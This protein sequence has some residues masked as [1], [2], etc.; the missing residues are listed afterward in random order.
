MAFHKSDCQCGSCA[1]YRRNRGVFSLAS[2]IALK[3]GVDHPERRSYFADWSGCCEKPTK[4]ARYV[5]SRSHPETVNRPAIPAME[6]YML[7]PCRR[8]APCLQF[9]QMKWRERAN[10]E[11]DLAHWKGNRTWIMC[12]TFSPVHLAHIL[13]SARTKELKDVEREAYKHVQRFFKRLRKGGAV[14]R[15]LAVYERGEKTGRSH[16]H[17]LLHEAD[18]EIPKRYLQ[19]SWGSM[20]HCHLVSGGSGGVASYVTKY[21]TKSLNI[22]PRSSSKYGQPTI[23]PKFISGEIQHT[24]KG[25]G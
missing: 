5:T 24:V 7:V 8:C 1:R 21:T 16:Y 18:K 17:V 9:R 13:L 11:L 22:R 10:I 4:V 20:S 6:V 25:E 14:F 23:P 2:K 15:Y 3:G 19:K 12:L